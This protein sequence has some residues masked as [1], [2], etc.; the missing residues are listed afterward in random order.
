MHVIVYIRPRHPLWRRRRA[1][2]VSIDDYFGK[3]VTLGVGLEP[4]EVMDHLR[5]SYRGCGEQV[6]RWTSATMSE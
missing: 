1:S 5:R 2:A 4:G 6:K 3:G